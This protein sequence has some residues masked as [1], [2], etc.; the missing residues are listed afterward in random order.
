MSLSR[1]SRLDPE[2]ESRYLQEIGTYIMHN[3]PLIEVREYCQE[4]IRM[5]MTHLE[6][7]LR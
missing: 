2:T 4:F 3:L 1:Q 5:Y 7:P 6:Q